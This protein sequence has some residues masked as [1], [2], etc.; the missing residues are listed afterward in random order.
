MFDLYSLVMLPI[1]YIRPGDRGEGESL[2]A[3]DF[4]SEHSDRLL[5]GS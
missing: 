3:L 2:A 1:W 5:E 4:D